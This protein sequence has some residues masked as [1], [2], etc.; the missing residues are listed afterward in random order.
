MHSKLLKINFSLIIMLWLSTAPNAAPLIIDHTCTDLSQIPNEWISAVKNSA[1]MYY[2]HTSHG[3]QLHEGL[4]SIE[5]SDSFYGYAV[6]GYGVPAEDD[7]FR[8]YAQ[9]IYDN[10][11]YTDS[12]PGAL[13]AFPAINYSMYCWCS[14]LDSFSA[15]QVQEYL[16]RMAA[17]ETAYP[18]VTFIYMTGNAQ[19]TGSAGYNRHLRNEQIRSWVRGSQN[20]VLYDF[21]DL[22]SWW[23]NPGTAQWEQA[24]YTYDR[25]TVPMEHPRYDGDEC[26]HTTAESCV[27][28]GKAVWW[29]MARLVQRE[30]GNT[31]SSS[32]YSNTT[33][34]ALPATTSL[35]SSSSSTSSFP[36]TTISPSSTTTSA[37]NTSTTSS[38][39][40]TTT[41][42]PPGACVI[43]KIYGEASP[44]A[45]LCRHVRDILNNTPAGREI[46][47]LY[48][49]HNLY[50]L[51]LINEDREFEEKLRS[52]MDRF[53]QFK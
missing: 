39:H 19:A 18:A 41:I 23:Y 50:L 9:S 29:M 36:P 7:A 6:D 45:A 31:T 33:T 43:E 3:S 20:R 5:S 25:Q 47:R 34:T 49:Q 1:V 15:A 28:K 46:V 48:Y 40:P 16:A 52:V 30:P 22:D 12:L 37:P 13:S 24:T 21:A 42:S 8:A 35:I 38:A 2:A 44:E 53:F 51:A 11:V 4:R 32:I 10:W 17:L 26:G 27:Q 14:Q